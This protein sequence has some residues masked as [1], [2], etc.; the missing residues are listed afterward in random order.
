[1]QPVVHAQVTLDTGCTLPHVPH[2][3]TFIQVNFMLVAGWAGLI[4]N[5]LACIPAGELDGARM[6]LGLWGRRAT[7]VVS[8]W[9]QL[10][11][12]FSAVFSGN[13][14]SFTWL[15]LIVFLLVR[16]VWFERE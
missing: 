11:L 5:S 10:V 13:A 6:A 4:A 16:S 15:L 14:L 9:T 1:M 8:L 2:P 3:A 7:N 12:G